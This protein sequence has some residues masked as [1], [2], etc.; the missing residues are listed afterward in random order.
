MHWPT[1]QTITQDLHS[2]ESPSLATLLS[3]ACLWVSGILFFLPVGLPYATADLL[4]SATD[5]LLGHTM[6]TVN[7]LNPFLDLQ[8]TL[9]WVISSW[10]PSRAI[11][12]SPYFMV[13]GPTGLLSKCPIERPSCPVPSPLPG[14]TVRFSAI[15]SL[16]VGVSRSHIGW[17]V[18]L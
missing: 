12:Y 1:L 11:V 13:S 14:E 10:G 3:M 6:L 15:F 17:W 18:S 5:C 7:C 9:P 4:P 2:M 8:L 16:G